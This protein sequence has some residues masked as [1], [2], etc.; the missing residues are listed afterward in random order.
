MSMA[1]RMGPHTIESGVG[2]RVRSIG[3]H[4]I[5]LHEVDAGL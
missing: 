2:Q 3:E 1:S 4:D 5:K